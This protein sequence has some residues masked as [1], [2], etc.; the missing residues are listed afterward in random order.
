MRR[1]SAGAGALQHPM[2]RFLLIAAA[3]LLA[4][5]APASA[6]LPAG[7]FASPDVEFIENHATGPSSGGKLV[8]GY[9]Y[10]TTGRDLRIF[11]VKDPEHPEQVGL[12]EL[13]SPGQGEQR[14]PEE[15]PDTNGTVLL[16]TN[17]GNLQVYDVRDKT[18]PKLWAELEGVDQ[19]TIT[20]ILDCTWAYGSEGEIIDL[21]DPAAPKQAG[22][23]LEQSEAGSPHDVT[24]IAPGL[25]LTATVPMQLLDVRTDPTKPTILASATAPGFVHQTLWPHNGTDDMFMTAGESL[26]PEC[27]ENVDAT[28]ATWSAGDWRTTK[29]FT[30]LKQFA[31]GNGV[32]VQGQ[33]PALTFC[34]HW[35]TPNPDFRNGGLVAIGWYEHGTRFLGV[36]QDGTITELGWFL[37]SG[38]RSSAAYFIT[39]RVVYIADYYRG[40]DVVKWNGVIPPSA[41][42]PTLT[43]GSTGG[44]TGGTPATTPARSPSFS[45]YVKLPSAKRCVRSLKLRV[46]RVAADPARSVDV[47]VNGKRTARA[48]GAKL[49]KPIRVKRVPRKKFTLQVLVKTR[50]GR[51]TAGARTYRPCASSRQRTR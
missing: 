37:P 45:D 4:A 5:A 17:G 29:T 51:T 31:M 36:A 10:L 44:P 30:L 12:L 24:E 19:H 49:R 14:A 3:A 39:D 42:A 1:K 35:F 47:R 27:A 11:D 23:W 9:F 20:C 48:K 6:Q 13:T 34:V 33:S 8:G 40:L 18:A 21:R 15:D 46:R 50:S 2:L 41:P 32:P 22:N 26:G 28:F 7:G 25:V 43:G 16:T 38:T